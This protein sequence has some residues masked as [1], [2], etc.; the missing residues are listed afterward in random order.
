MH[1]ALIRNDDLILAEATK[2]LGTQKAPAVT[3]NALAHLN[4]G[5]AAYAQK[6]Y[7]RAV[8]ELDRALSI[9]RNIAEAYFY[10]GAAYSVKG[11]YDRAI[12]DYTAALRINP[13]YA[14]AYNNRGNAYKNKE[15]YDRAIADYN[16]ALRINPNDAT[17]KDGLERARRARGY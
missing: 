16:A 4:N 6:D 9:N 17:A 12:A 14:N 3:K 7:D 5:K 2:P 1:S 10:R 15:D 11:D 13:T 8:A